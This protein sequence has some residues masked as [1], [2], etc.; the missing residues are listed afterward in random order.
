MAL[1]NWMKSHLIM[2]AVLSFFGLIT[3][4]YHF[5]KSEPEPIE[6][7]SMRVELAQKKQI[8]Q[9]KVIWKKIMTQAE[10]AG[11]LGSLDT[12]FQNLRAELQNDF[13]IEAQ[14]GE[15]SQYNDLQKEFMCRFVEAC[16][17]DT[18][19][20]KE[21]GNVLHGVGIEFRFDIRYSASVEKGYIVFTIDNEWAEPKNVLEFLK[22]PAVLK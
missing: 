13:G 7:P 20:A 6:Q 22:S 4:N 17:V 15:C 3:I 18:H 19:T 2:M 21:I 11:F 14:T 1:I 16:Y 12:H 10:R 8:F 5:H 9:H